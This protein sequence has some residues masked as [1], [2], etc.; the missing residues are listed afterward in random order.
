MSVWFG[1]A[2]PAGTPTTVLDKLHDDVASV[3]KQ[4]QFNETFIK[5]QAYIAGTDSRAELAARVK[6]E[7]AKWG[8]L[9]KISGAKVQQ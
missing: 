1:F 2:A 3:L 7:H 5:P 9:V 6:A 4:P 8:E